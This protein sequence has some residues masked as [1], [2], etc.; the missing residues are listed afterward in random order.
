MKKIILRALG[1]LL[2]LIVALVVNTIWFKPF[3]I[4]AFYE[5]VFAQ[6]AFDSPELLSRLQLVEGV[7][8]QG[9]NRQ[10]DDASDE[11]ASRQFRRLRA[12]LVMLH[13]YDTTGMRG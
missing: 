12:D 2:L 3:F 5:K 9:H 13:R 8:M 1:V 6:V 4:R 10:L 11:E 7:D